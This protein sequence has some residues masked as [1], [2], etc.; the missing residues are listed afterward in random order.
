M[1]HPSESLS[2]MIISKKKNTHNRK[3]QNKM[4]EKIRSSEFF[5]LEEAEI[6]ATMYKKNKKLCACSSWAT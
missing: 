2:T 4:R 1:T 6:E 3:L 5:S